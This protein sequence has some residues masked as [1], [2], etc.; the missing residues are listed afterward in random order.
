VV[1]KNP[2][3][4]RAV[5]DTPHAS[6]ASSTSKVEGGYPV[7]VV[8]EAAART[9]EQS[10]SSPVAPV[11]VSASRTDLG[12][13]SWVDADHWDSALQCLVSDIA[14][15]FSEGPRVESRPLG[16]PEVRSISYPVQVLEDHHISVTQAVHEPSAHLVEHRVCPS[17]LPV[18]EPFQPTFSRPRAFG[19]EGGS[20]LPEVLP[21]SGYR[22][23]LD[24]EAV[25]GHE[26]VVHPHIYTNRIVS[27]GFWSLA[28]DGD[29]EVEPLL[30]VGEYGVGWPSPAQELP[31]VFPYCEKRFD[32]F[33]DRGDGSTNSIWSAN[34]PE[35]SRVEIERELVEAEEPVSS[36][37]VRFGYPI[38]GA[39][40]EV[41]GE[42]ELGPSFTVDEVVESDRVENP[43][44]ECHL[45]DVVAGILELLDGAKQLFVLLVREPELADD[46]FGELHWKRIYAFFY[47]RIQQFLPQLRWR[48]SLRWLI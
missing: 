44:F 24:L 17:P 29:V 8:L 23:A 45:R 16:L 13:V 47:L 4:I 6:R 20:Q 2:T 18:A 10:L 46:S 26:E 15:Q 19:L 31:L 22:F 7:R 25:G 1:G 34:Q 48:V 36:L 30:L 27:L 40:C 38:P 28:V 42:P 41:G 37:L 14:L 9:P 12:S 5:D 11:D 3:N 35:E 39:D 21:F 33:L 32:A 43:P